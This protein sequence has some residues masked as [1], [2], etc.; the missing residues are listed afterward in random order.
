MPWRGMSLRVQ[1]EGLLHITLLVPHLGGE[2]PRFFLLST[3]L[4]ADSVFARVFE[5]R[6]HFNAVSPRAGVGV[7]GGREGEGKRKR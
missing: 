6:K 2:L 7:G 1:P 3:G 5:S 4:L